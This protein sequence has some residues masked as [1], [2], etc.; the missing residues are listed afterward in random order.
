ME[1]ILITSWNIELY[2]Y[3]VFGSRNQQ[4]SFCNVWI[5]ISYEY[6]NVEYFLTLIHYRCYEEQEFWYPTFWRVFF[7]IGCKCFPV[8]FVT[9][10]GA[11]GY[12]IRQLRRSWMTWGYEN[13]LRDVAMVLGR[14]V[15]SKAK[16]SGVV[17]PSC[18]KGLHNLKE[19][20]M[21]IIT[22]EAHIEFPLPS[23]SDW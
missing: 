13:R 10:L 6:T 14:E 4:D 8:H 17:G 20:D 23:P 19:Q 11:L 18:G 7:D 3:F 9:C 5:L 16:R 12:T 21:V 1:I 2:G 22:L 15:Q